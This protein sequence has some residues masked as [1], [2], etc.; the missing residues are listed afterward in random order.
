MKKELIVVLVIVAANRVC[1][2]KSRKVP[3]SL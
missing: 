3:Q 2:T 1:G